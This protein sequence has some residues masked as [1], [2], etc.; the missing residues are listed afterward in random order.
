MT[1]RRV[2]SLRDQLAERMERQAAKVQ[3]LAMEASRLAEKAGETTD[4]KSWWVVSVSASEAVRELRL[5]RQAP[6]IHLDLHQPLERDHL[7]VPAKKC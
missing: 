4:A 7:G 3:M 1:A 2:R 6:E 5:L